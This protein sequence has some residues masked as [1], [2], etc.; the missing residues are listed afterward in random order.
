MSEREDVVEGNTAPKLEDI[1]NF[2]VV[3]IIGNQANEYQF[4][5]ADGT[6]VIANIVSI[7]TVEQ[8][9]AEC[10]SEIA[11]KQAELTAMQAKKVELE[12]IAKPVEEPVEELAKE[13]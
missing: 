9:K 3:E 4:I 10:D 1:I 2:D 11:Q 5:L 7:K 13:L 12:L 8:R 6:V